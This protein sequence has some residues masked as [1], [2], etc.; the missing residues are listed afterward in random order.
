MTI[1]L[2][3][4]SSLRTSQWQGCGFC[5]FDRTGE[6]SFSQSLSSLTQGSDVLFRACPKND[7]YFV[8]SISCKVFSG[9]FLPLKRIYLLTRELLR[10]KSITNSWYTK[11]KFQK[12][13]KS[14]SVLSFGKCI[15]IY[16]FSKTWT[17]R[18]ISPVFVLCH[19]ACH[20]IRRRWQPLL[21]VW[22]A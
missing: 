20:G 8:I 9:M 21:N 2:L 10:G 3:S 14:Y 15:D 4:A 16:M 7:N 5:H 18:P 6:I 12:Y 11:Q 22:L 13:Y 17:N 19:C 1:I